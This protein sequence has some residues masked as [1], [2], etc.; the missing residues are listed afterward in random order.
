MTRTLR[1]P[2]VLMAP[3]VLVLLLVTAWPLGRA[4]WTSLST[5]A[6]TTPDDTSFVGVDNYVEVLTSRQWWVAVALTLLFVAVVV[7]L[8]LLLAAGF[9]ATLRRITVASAYLRVLVLVPFATLAVVTAFAWRDGLTQGFGPSWFRYDGDGQVVGLLAAAAAEV[10][11]G[12]GITTIILLAGLARVPVSLLESAAAD[13]ATGRQR[14][15]RVV[16]PAAAPAIAVAVV[17]RAL[18]VYRAFEAPLLAEP[19][20]PKL[21]TAPLLL[22]DTTFTS[23]ELGLGAAMSV[24]V[25]VLAG[26]VGIG[27]MLTL[28]VRRT[29]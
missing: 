26:L 14:L 23:F 28:R 7:L 24:L 27:L 10:W 18:D 22:W 29:L 20:L 4:V 15:F 13:G 5:S 11:R 12:T 2:E 21:R 6:L 16:L 1:R 19:S 9:A 3:A 8:Q 17:Y 25:L